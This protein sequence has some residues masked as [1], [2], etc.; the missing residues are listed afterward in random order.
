MIWLLSPYTKGSSVLYRKF[1]HPTLSNKEKV[2]WDEGSSLPICPRSRQP[3][4]CNH[5]HSWLSL[6]VIWQGP[7]LLGQAVPLSRCEQGQGRAWP[8]GPT[9]HLFLL[10]LRPLRRSTSIHHTGPRQEL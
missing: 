4:A 6:W 3:S 5:V 2:C 10:P 7:G 8:A 1:V 9:P